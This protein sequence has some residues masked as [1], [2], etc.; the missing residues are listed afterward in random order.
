MYWLVETVMGQFYLGRRLLGGRWERWWVDM[1][2][3]AEIWHSVSPTAVRSFR[4]SAL[5]RGN[6]VREFHRGSSEAEMNRATQEAIARRNSHVD[7]GRWIM[8]G[9]ELSARVDEALVAKEQLKAAGREQRYGFTEAGPT[10]V[11]VDQ[12]EVE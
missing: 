1:P 8:E 6:P 10:R 5:C 11:P 12:L 7:I 4:P 2:V 3:C 9:T